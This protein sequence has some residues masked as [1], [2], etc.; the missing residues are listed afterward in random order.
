MD[1]NTYNNK[2][3]PNLIGNIIIINDSNEFCKTEIKC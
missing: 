1:I 3:I 2:N